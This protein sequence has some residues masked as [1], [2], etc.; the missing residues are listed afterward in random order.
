MLLG[1]VLAGMNGVRAEGASPLATASGSGPIENARTEAE[2][3][4]PR[5][6][7]PTEPACPYSVQARR[8]LTKPWP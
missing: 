2:A 8:A 4:R 7:R 5:P 6:P 3:G 1:L